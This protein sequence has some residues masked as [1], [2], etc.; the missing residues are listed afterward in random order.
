MKDDEWHS[1]ACLKGPAHQEQGCVQKYGSHLER[2][3]ELSGTAAVG[4]PERGWFLFSLHQGKNQLS[5]KADMGIS[6]TLRTLGW[7]G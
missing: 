5:S 7:S 1:G 3:W 6:V 4:E 2:T